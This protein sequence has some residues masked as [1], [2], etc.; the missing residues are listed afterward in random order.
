ME[1]NQQGSSNL[2]LV[3]A[4]NIY[5][6]QHDQGDHHHLQASKHAKDHPSHLQAI[7]G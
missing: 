1:I 5:M 4:T 2:T 6:Q 3:A 7:L